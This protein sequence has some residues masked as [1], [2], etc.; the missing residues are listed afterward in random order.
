MTEKEKIKR[1][2]APILGGMTG[3]LTSSKIKDVVSG[4]II[5]VVVASGYYIISRKI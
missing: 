5:T 4:I 3:F 2:A 1:I